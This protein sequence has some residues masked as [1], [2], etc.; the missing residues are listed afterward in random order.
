V[1]L[2]VADQVHGV[3]RAAAQLRPGEAPGHAEHEEQ[4]R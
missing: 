4:E 3:F 1:Q 2:E